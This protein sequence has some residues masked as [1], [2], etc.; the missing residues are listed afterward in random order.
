MEH[1]DYCNQNGSIK[2]KSML[3]RLDLDQNVKCDDNI[4]MQTNK[5]TLNK[6]RIW[7]ADLY[8]ACLLTWY[9]SLLV[10]GSRSSGDR[11]QIKNARSQFR[12]VRLI[13][14]TDNE[15]HVYTLLSW[16]PSYKAYAIDVSFL[17]RP[18]AMNENRFWNVIDFMIRNQI[19]MTQSILMSCSCL[20]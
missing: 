16:G 1:A 17:F 4:D 18:S 15:S 11:S 6:H 8:I 7:A 19:L 2:I 5:Q 20:N 10:G 12:R 14:I 9:V 3:Q 13:S